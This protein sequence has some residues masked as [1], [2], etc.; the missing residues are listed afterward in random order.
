MYTNVRMI[1]TNTRYINICTNVII[2]IIN[3]DNI[4]TNLSPRVTPRS[5]IAVVL[6]SK[7]FEKLVRISITLKHFLLR[8]YSG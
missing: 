5:V 3:K 2:A 1:K 4:D 7:I 8:S 6:D